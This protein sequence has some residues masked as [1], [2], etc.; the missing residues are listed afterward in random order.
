MGPLFIF[1]MKIVKAGL[2]TLSESGVLYQTGYFM[3]ATAT[4]L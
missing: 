1:L 3:L 4:A 2:I